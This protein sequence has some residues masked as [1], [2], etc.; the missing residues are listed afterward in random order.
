MSCIG[1]ALCGMYRQDG[2]NHKQGRALSRERESAAIDAIASASVSDVAG[3]WYVGAHQG[4][5]TCL[6]QLLSDVPPGFPWDLHH[7][8]DRAI[9]FIQSN[10]RVQFFN[11]VDYD[12]RGKLMQADMAMTM[13]ASGNSVLMLH[14]AVDKGGRTRVTQ[15]VMELDSS[16]GVQFIRW[17]GRRGE[18]VWQRMSS[19][20][21]L[22]AKQVL[23]PI[24]PP[25]SLAC[26][27][28]PDKLAE[29]LQRVAA[30]TT[31]A[32]TAAVSTSSP[33]AGSPPQAV[34]PLA[35]MSVSPLE[36]SPATAG[37][38]S[39]AGDTSRPNAGDVAMTEALV[40]AWR[41]VSP[42]QVASMSTTMATT[43][44]MPPTILVPLAR[45][46]PTEHQPT[47]SMLLSCS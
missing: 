19:L 42:P 40:T 18:S 41:T 36:P 21:D 31:T 46:S 32:A 13:C 27:M 6:W 4:G 29:F 16:S 34:S 45:A 8:D 2:M 1:C 28:R 11:G 39:S 24:S 14:T 15:G 30:T 22:D 5:G 38:R 12:A 23:P 47:G 9:S 20:E 35:L 33:L 7:P 44:V 3:L 37:A 10:P 17:Q 43:S 25:V 26:W